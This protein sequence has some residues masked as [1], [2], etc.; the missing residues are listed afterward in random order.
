MGL[1]LGTTIF[2]NFFRR[3]FIAVFSCFFCAGVL[4]NVFEAPNNLPEG[5]GWGCCLLFRTQSRLVVAAQ[6]PKVRREVSTAPGHGAT[7]SPHWRVCYPGYKIRTINLFFLPR[8][9]LCT[10]GGVKWHS[11]PNLLPEDSGTWFMSLVPNSNAGAISQRQVQVFRSD[12]NSVFSAWLWP[13][14]TFLRVSPSSKHLQ[15]VFE[16]L[17]GVTFL[18]DGVL[19][20]NVTGPSEVPPPAPSGSGHETS[21]HYTKQQ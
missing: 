8:D 15:C 20:A 12:S 4:G 13:H 9:A 7:A 11:K 14:F 16:A 10:C 18:Q 2:Y 3:Q 1:A 6:S 17:K 5:T 21:S 19:F